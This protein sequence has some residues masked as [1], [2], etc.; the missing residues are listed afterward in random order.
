MLTL[1]P[2]VIISWKTTTGETSAT[3][4]NKPSLNPQSGVNTGA[5]PVIADHLFQRICNLLVQM[6]NGL[7]LQL[8]MEDVLDSRDLSVGVAVTRR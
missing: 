2:E 7:R 1:Q 3:Q 5:T 8:G 4:V 6:V